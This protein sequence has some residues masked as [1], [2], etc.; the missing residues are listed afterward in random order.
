MK[1]KKNMKRYPLKSQ[2]SLQTPPTRLFQNEEKLTLPRKN[3][4]LP[5]SIRM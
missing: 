1:V 5:Y 3:M 2:K 4:H